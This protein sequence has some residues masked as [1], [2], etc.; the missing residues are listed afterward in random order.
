VERNHGRFDELV[1]QG[2]SRHGDGGLWPH[3]GCISNDDLLDLDDVIG[4]RT[5]TTRLLANVVIGEE[6]AV[7]ALEAMS[8]FGVDP[9]YKLP[10]LLEHPGEAFANC[11]VSPACD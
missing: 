6:Q 8:R 5:V 4:R 7:T 3:A 11:S 9:R 1:G 10:G 2:L